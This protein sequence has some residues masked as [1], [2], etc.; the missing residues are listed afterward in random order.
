MG[1]QRGDVAVG[2]VEVAPWLLDIAAAA[3]VA[4][5][6]AGYLELQQLLLCFGS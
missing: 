4:D 1:E 6:A 3:L 2:F 5:V